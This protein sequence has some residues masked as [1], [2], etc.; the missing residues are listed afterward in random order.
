VIRMIFVKH[1]AICIGNNLVFSR[2][3][4]PKYL[5]IIFLV[6]FPIFF[7]INILLFL[8]FEFRFILV[9]Q[10]FFAWRWKQINVD[11]T[12]LPNIEIYWIKLLDFAFYLALSVLLCSQRFTPLF[13]EPTFEE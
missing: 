7:H 9:A 6:I 8:R 10:I 2:Y 3:V 13:S 11:K 4:Y 5:I 12:L 1:S